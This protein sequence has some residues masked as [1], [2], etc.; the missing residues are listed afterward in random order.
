MKRILATAGIAGIAL[1]G[2]TAP[3]NAGD[4]NKVSICHA[5]GS[6]SNPYVSITVSENAVNGNGGHASHHGD[7]IPAPSGG[8]PGGSKGDHDPKDDD[9][10]H[11]SKKVTI[12]H[13]TGSDKNPY[14]VITIPEK[15]WWNGHKDGHNGR[16]DIYPVPAGGCDVKDEEEE[17]EEPAAGRSPAR[18]C[19]AGRNTAG[20]GP[21]GSDPAGCG[22]AGCCRSCRPEP[23]RPRLPPR[24]STADSTPRLLPEPRQMPVCPLGSE[25]WLHCL[26]PRGWSPCGTGDACRTSGRR[27]KAVPVVRTG[28]HRYGA[29]PVHTYT[30]GGVPMSFPYRHDVDSPPLD[31]D[32]AAP[33]AGGRGG[34]PDDGPAEDRVPEDG[35]SV[36]GF[37]RGGAR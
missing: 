36:D 19:P 16:A 2:V 34:A 3:A 4:N 37:R 29:M 30:Y 25:A 35:V 22:P 8:C 18:C 26:A 23:Q 13:A 31:G 10:G 32:I 9:D 15:A 28:I 20:R 33:G 1:I 7:L 27:S 21:A 5:T 6:E 14:V 12:C 24:W 11:G 17:E